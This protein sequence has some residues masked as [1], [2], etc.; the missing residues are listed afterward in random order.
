MRV[1]I[2]LFTFTHSPEM[3]ENGNSVSPKIFKSTR[4]FKKKVFVVNDI[5]SSVFAIN[6]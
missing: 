5:I 4:N 2:A 1:L 6:K 3:S